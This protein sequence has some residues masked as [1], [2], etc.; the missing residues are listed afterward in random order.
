LAI[1]LEVWSDYLCPWCNVAT[2]RLE[3][4]AAEVGPE[5]ELHWKS[6]LLRPAP[7][8]GRDLEKFRRYTELWQRAAQE[9]PTAEFHTWASD[10]GPPSH[11]VPAHLVAKAAATLGPEPFYLMHHAL[12]H[13]YFVQSRDISSAKTLAALWREIGLPEAELSRAMA[14]EL[15]EQIAA[16]H[17]E[18]IQ[19]GVSG[20]PAVRMVG[21]DVAIS[22]A[23]PL[24]VYRRWV[25]RTL[26]AGAQEE[27]P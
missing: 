12:L 17:N 6:F 15:L 27:S 1:T 18:A 14:P 8:P 22:G 26:E 13:A 11:S 24:E 4:V 19:L 25:R 2:N 3:R 10:E 16:E 21:N 5:L 23:Q 9:E 20:V 7:E